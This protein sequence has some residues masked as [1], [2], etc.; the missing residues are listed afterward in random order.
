MAKDLIVAI[1]IAKPDWSKVCTAL[2][3]KIKDISILQ[4]MEHTAEKGL[5]ATKTIPD[6]IMIDDCPESGD[7][8]SRIKT[9]KRSFPQTALFVVSGNKDPQ[10]II[11]VMKSG[12]SEY[13]VEPVSEELVF[14][15]INEI[16][17]NLAD[18]GRLAHGRI[19]SFV[20]AK[21]GVGSTVLA[22]NTAAA[23][24]MHKKTAV[25]LLDMSFQSGDA[26]VLL[27]IVPQNTIMDICTNM[28]RLDVSFLRGVM[29]GHSTGMNF[30]PAPLN[31]ED[32]DEIHSEHIAAIL[33]LARK[34]YDHIVID[35][36]P[37]YVSDCSI[38][39]FK[40][41]DKVFIVTDMSVPSIRNTVRLCKLIRK[42]GIGLENIEIIINRYIK[43]GALSLAEIEKNF[44][45]PVYWLAPNDFG[46]IVSSINRGVPLVKLS[47]GAPFSKNM[48]EFTKKFQG[49]LGDQS[50]RG[51]RGTFGKVI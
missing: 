47:P 36:G 17:A 24:A 11:S 43:G 37:S 44:D 50:F 15:A 26:S 23:L 4:W 27:D 41:S 20:S 12:A 13:L 34:L 28:H 29:T 21:G 7:L 49:I 32:S 16:R 30:L 40:R 6:I 25:A 8:F 19:Y 42:L 31:P 45:K 3:K 5:I 18:S 38:E 39:A 33:N 22:V 14:S 10:H 46:Q 2:I 35:C 1:Q 9:I 48:V 51:I